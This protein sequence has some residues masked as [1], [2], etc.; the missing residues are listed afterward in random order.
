MANY[1]KVLNGQWIKTAII[2]TAFLKVI[3]LLPD[4]G[5]GKGKYQVVVK[6]GDINYT[7][8]ESDYD[9]LALAQAALDAF[10]GTL[11]A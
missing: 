5:V 1:I 9:T 11:N 6:T 3:E 4:T 2:D 8:S 7:I 10:A